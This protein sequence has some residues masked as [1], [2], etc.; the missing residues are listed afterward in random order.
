MS[1][2]L[3]RYSSRVTQP[4]SQ[5]ASQAM[6]YKAGLTEADMAKAQMGISSV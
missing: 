5:D 1:H 2:K 4:K 6:L 3:N